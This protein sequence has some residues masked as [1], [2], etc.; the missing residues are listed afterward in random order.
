MSL[1]V[2]INTGDDHTLRERELIR[3]DA[4]GYLIDMSCVMTDHC[5]STTPA[6]SRV[7]L[8]Q[9]IRRMAH[10][11][12][13]VVTRLS[14][15][16][17][18]LADVINTI[19]L[20]GVKHARCHCLE[21]GGADLCALDAAAPL[22]VLQSASRLEADVKRA[23]AREVSAACRRDGIPQGRP[24]SLSGEQRQQAL[25]ELANG[26]SVTEVAKMLDTSRQTII[27]IREGA[28]RAV[29]NVAASEQP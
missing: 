8:Q 7:G 23:R 17:A 9:L 13:L 25:R 3:I 21:I 10:G 5:S 6:V 22:R 20:L 14:F 29:T 27:R 2:Y 4:S 11:D 1:F 19:T 12:T 15:L 16:G 18:G 24:A 28:A 26:H